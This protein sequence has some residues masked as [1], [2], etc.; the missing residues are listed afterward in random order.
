M[1]KAPIIAF[2]PAQMDACALYRMFIPHLN[3]P[4]SRFLFNPGQM[5]LHQFVEA[6]VVVVQRQVTYSNYLAIQELKKYG[7]RVVYDMDDNLWAVPKENPSFKAFK[8]MR[9][10]F[11]ECASQCD[12]I[13]VSTSGL[14]TAVRTALSPNVRIEVVPNAIDFD[15]FPEPR[16]RRDDGRVVI[17]WGGSNTHDV[18]IK[19]AWDV[20]PEIVLGHE[21]VHLEVV[22][23]AAPPK[24]LVGHPRVRFRPWVATGEYSQR[25]AT[26]AWDILLAPLEDGRFNKSKS[27]IKI[28][29]TAAVGAVCLVSDVQPYS[30]FF[31]LAKTQWPVCRTRLDWREKLLALV[32]DPKLR[33]EQAAEIRR[34]AKQWYDIQNIKE[35]W[36]KVCS[37]LLR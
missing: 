13:T 32:N 19:A 6:S 14:A 24:E 26:W 37:D 31:R 29:E 35:M 25:M 33:Q 16:T 10:G 3:I 4:G 11:A 15:L 30:D 20:L 18:D 21:H 7:M 34:V 23:G 1:S 17:G 22:G 12:L 36:I 28:L 5:A 9:S 27:N 8:E 2:L